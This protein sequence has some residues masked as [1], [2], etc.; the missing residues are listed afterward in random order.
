MDDERPRLEA[1]YFGDDRTGQWAR[2]VRVLA[3]TAAQHCATW[4]VQ[5]R[6]IVPPRLTSALGI[7]SHVENTQ[8]MEHWHQLVT[9][10]PDGTRL[11]MIDADTIILHPLD[12]VWER[13]FDLAYTT[14]E[15]RFPFN[16]GVI[17]ARVSPRLR[18]F[19]AAWRK[20]NRRMLGDRWHHQ[21]WRKRFGGINQAS[22]GYML[23]RGAQDG[24]S[25]A[26]LPCVEWNCEDASWASY[27]S[28]TRIVHVKSSLR[29]SLFLRAHVAPAH[30]RPLITLWRHLEREA[31]DAERH[32]APPAAESPSPRS[33]VA[34]PESAAQ[35]VDA[36]APPRPRGRPRAPQETVVA[37]LRLPQ[38]VYDA[39]CRRALATRTP[40][41]SVVSSALRGALSPGGASGGV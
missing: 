5:I 17:F 35:T 25:L 37:H 19:I 6:H 8:K 12:D 16:S 41:A 23:E 11:L 3:Y 28:A 34:S 10:A 36:E 14:K 13:D 20:E 21:I 39:Y 22:F 24:L 7:A 31:L 27:S 26:T 9:A 33:E 4:D 18:A 29:A 32:P 40:L 30:L 15:S 1:C 2:M 38:D